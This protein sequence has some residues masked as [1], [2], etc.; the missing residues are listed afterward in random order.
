MNAI[1]L[2]VIGLA[3]TLVFS[4]CSG[5]GPEEHRPAVYRGGQNYGDAIQ[6]ER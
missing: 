5:P 6:G 1:A 2:L 3:L 4:G